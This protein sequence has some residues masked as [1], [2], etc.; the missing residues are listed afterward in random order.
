MNKK[1]IS[2]ALVAGVSISAFAA[3]KPNI[4]IIF[5]DDQGYQDLG[6]Y[7]SPN[8]KTP[9]VDQLAREGMRFTDH[10]VASSVC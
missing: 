9:R 4:I 6:C 2:L 8:I 1:I 10:Y 7:G 5:N 3:K